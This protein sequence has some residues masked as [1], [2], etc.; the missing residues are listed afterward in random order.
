M[1]V[2]FLPTIAMTCM[3]LTQNDSSLGT[4]SDEEG[5]FEHFNKFGLD[6][7]SI[8]IEY[9]TE[10]SRFCANETPTIEGKVVVKT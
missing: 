7:K 8:C 10:S 3:A 5:I 6:Q 9:V 2:L 4:W 1:R